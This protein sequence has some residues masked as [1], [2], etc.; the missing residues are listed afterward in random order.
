MTFKLFFF[1]YILYCLSFFHLRLP[2]TFKLFFFFYILYCLSFFH[3][4][5]PMTFK[6][7]FFL[8]I[9][10]CLS[11]LIYGFRW[12]SNCS[13]SFTYFIVCPSWPPMTF[14]LFFFFY[15]LYCLS[16]FDIRLPVTFK[17]F[18]FSP[19]SAFV[20]YCLSFCP[21]FTFISSVLLGVMLQMTSFVSS[22]IFRARNTNL[23]FRLIA[24][25]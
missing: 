14:K 7:F 12:P 19:C 20:C 10:Y 2:M 8:Y 11:F 1:F 13:F 21:Y 22:N 17:L 9:L 23:Y 25:R 3:L 18:F 4:R 24:W 6:L 16:F 5:L 15:I